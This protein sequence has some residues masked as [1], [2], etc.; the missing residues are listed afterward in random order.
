MDQPTMLLK[1]TQARLRF[2]QNCRV[3]SAK[4]TTL[5][6]SNE[7]LSHRLDALIDKQARLIDRLNALLAR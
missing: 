4:I 7:R 1:N 2:T 5:Q 6:T 3:L